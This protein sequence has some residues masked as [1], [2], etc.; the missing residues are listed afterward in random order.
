MQTQ[1]T[2]PASSTEPEGKPSDRAALARFGH[3]VDMAVYDLDIG[4]RDR[5]DA[6][7]LTALAEIFTSAALEIAESQIHRDQ[8]TTT[9]RGLLLTLQHRDP[10]LHTDDA[11]L[12]FYTLADRL[13]NAAIPGTERKRRRGLVRQLVDLGS[14]SLA[15]SGIASTPESYGARSAAAMRTSEKVIAY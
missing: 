3:A 2:R 1:L 11:E 5:A 8:M 6:H 10:D 12:M 4:R 7:N 9:T 15:A 14:L 13:R